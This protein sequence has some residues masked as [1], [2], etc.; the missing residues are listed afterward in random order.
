MRRTSLFPIVGLLAI[1]S[2]CSSRGAAVGPGG[3]GSAAGGAG[4]A[5]GGAGSAAGGAGSAAGGAGSAAGAGSVS[6]AGETSSGGTPGTAGSM[7]SGAGGG[8]ESRGGAGGHAG[9]AGD[10]MGGA[11]VTLPTL[12]TSTLGAY[13]KTEGQLTEVTSGTVDVTIDDRAI[14]QLWTG[15]GGTFSERSADYLSLLSASDQEAAMKWLFGRDGLRFN[16]G[17]IPIGAS[18]YAIDRYTLDETPDDTTMAQFSIERDKQKLI[19]Y[20]KAAL[21]VAPELHLWASP[22]SPPTWMKSNNAF[23]GGSMKEDD[24]TLQAFALYLTKFVQE[25]AKLG[26]PVEVVHPQKEPNLELD[27][28][29]CLWSAAG[30]TKLIGSYLGPM[31][32]EHKV[33][34]QIFLGSLSEDDRQGR[35]QAIIDAVAGDAAGMSYIKGF[36]FEWDGLNLVAAV[37]P[38]NLPIWQDNHNVGNLPWSTPPGATFNPTTAPNDHAYA[39]TSWSFIR[40]WIQAG[41]DAYFTSNMILDSVGVGIGARAWPQNALLV[42]DPATKKLIITPAFYVFRHLSPFVDPGAHVVGTRGGDALAFKNP[43]GT[44]VA[45]LYN[46]GA[47]KKTVVAIGGKQLQFDMP[48]SGWA[49]LKVN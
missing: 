8:G 33:T 31:F 25:Y 1:A 42:V 36:G 26:V 48:G 2:A 35:A 3:A 7:P 11:T 6:I 37:K 19:P 4:S 29:S 12:V 38:K 17:R 30:M 21:A 15:F 49:T 23:D 43:D 45:V 46:S 20:I 5:A 13:W 18:D 9:W 44:I 22:W 34:A 27:F 47:A 32:A 28:P 24:A 14:A 39:V 16:Y 41:V 40:D 10:S